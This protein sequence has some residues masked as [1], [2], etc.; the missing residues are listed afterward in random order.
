MPSLECPSCGL[1]LKLSPKSAGRTG[2]CPQCG[3]RIRIP[4]VDDSPLKRPKQPADRRARQSSP[5]KKPVP[6]AQAQPV[7]ASVE[8]TPVDDGV[9]GLAGLSAEASAPEEAPPRSPVGSAR[10]RPK[11]HKGQELSIEITSPNWWADDDA[12]HELVCRWLQSE[13]S[14]YFRE[15]QESYWSVQLQLRVSRF[16]ITRA[17]DGFE[18]HG[19]VEVS[20]TVNG[21]ELQ[22]IFARQVDKLTLASAKTRGWLNVTSH[23]IRA[24]S[25]SARSTHLGADPEDRRTWWDTEAEKRV[26]ARVRYEIFQ[27]ML[28]KCDDYVGRKPAPSK[29]WLKVKLAAM[30]AYCLNGLV[31]AGVLAGKHREGGFVDWLIPGFIFALPMLGAALAVGMLFLPQKFF[32]SDSTGRNLVKF[33]GLSSADNVKPVCAAVAALFIAIEGGLWW[34][35]YST[36]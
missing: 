23:I 27:A 25:A 26:C 32:L 14:E 16:E 5:E 24:C 18:V 21:L 9:Y 12:R 8:T 36:M 22:Q 13:L 20:G 17:R 6:A 33:A 11:G 3:E 15:T 35:E 19:V 1:Q 30:A 28:E 10:R 2:K 34:M 7:G 4:N 31:A 29:M